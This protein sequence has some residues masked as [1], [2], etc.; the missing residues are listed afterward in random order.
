M[1][2]R[3]T[4]IILGSNVVETVNDYNRRQVLLWLFDFLEVVRILIFP[5]HQALKASLNKC[6][7]IETIYDAVQGAVVALCY[8]WELNRDVLRDGSVRKAGER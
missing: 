6:V 8:S 1:T 7:V 4:C 5:R 3:F 2:I